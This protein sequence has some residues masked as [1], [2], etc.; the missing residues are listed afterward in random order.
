[1]YSYIRNKNIKGGI[2][3]K[4]ISAMFFTFVVIGLT[5]FSSSNASAQT[6]YETAKENPNFSILASALERAGLDEAISSSSFNYTVLAPTNTAFETLL[7]EK[8]LTAA[9]LLDHP[10]LEKIL[11]THVIAAEFFKEDLDNYRSYFFTH[12]L[13]DERLYFRRIQRNPSQYTVNKI[14]ISNFDIDASNGVIHVIDQVIL[15]KG[16]R[17]I[18]ELDQTIYEVAKGNSDFSILATALEKSGLDEVANDPSINYTVLAPT[19]TAFEKLLAKYDLTAEQLL[20]SPDLAKILKTHIIGAEF[21]KEDL[22]HYSSYFFTRALSE[23][24]LYF[25][26]IQRNPSQYVVNK[27]PIVDFDINP[28]NG[29]IHVIDEVIIPS[30]VNLIPELDSTIYEVAKS[31]SDFSILTAALEKSGLDLVANDPSANVTVFAPTN[32]AFEKLLQDLD[33]TAEDLLN[34]EDL[35][36]ILKTHIVGAEFFKKDLDRYRSFFYTKALSDERLYFRRTSTNPSTYTVN[37]ISITNFDINPKN[38]AIHIIDEVIVPRNVNLM[39]KAT[40]TIYEIAKSNSNFSILALALEKSGLDSVANSASINYTVLAPTNAAFEKLL[41]ETQ[42]TADQLLNSPDLEKILTTHMIP[43]EFFKKD[44]D[45]YY[46]RFYTRALSKEKLFFE[47]VSQNPNR[48]TVNNISLTDFDI[49]ATNGAIHVLDE[50]IVPSSTILIPEID[51]TI[52]EVAKSNGNFTILV[53]AL[54]KTGLDSVFDDGN[55][56][57]TPVCSYRR[58]IRKVSR[59]KQPDI[60]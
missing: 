9:Q 56:N 32:A 2:T 31:N 14:P 53:A 60:G 54:E 26:R 16:V 58:A 3:M 37:G 15:P 38:G 25:R 39:P 36:R 20:N 57:V 42:L 6:L 18:P 47:R 48:Y 24:R 10:D 11:L 33:M 45:R 44:L 29:A 1:M 50:V 21:F 52:L 43:T 49:N 41:A 23:E 55:I 13:S 7:T 35:E 51:Q 30:S 12:A 17:L 22:D 46:P 28:S 8:N 34:A 59:S 40:S 19:N 5:S 27:I 4:K